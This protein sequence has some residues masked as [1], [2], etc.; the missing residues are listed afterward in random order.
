MNRLT[1]IETTYNGYKFRSRLEARWS[2]FFDR[3]NVA[4]DYES[5]GF[6]LSDVPQRSVPLVGVAARYL[7]DF[8]LPGQRTWVEVKPTQPTPI[9]HERLARLARAANTNAVIVIGQPWIVAEYPFGYDGR[10]SGISI[11]PSGHARRF[12]LL[13][14]CPF[15]GVVDWC[16]DGDAQWLP[17]S[18]P[19]LPRSVGDFARVQRA[20]LA[21]RSARFEFGQTPKAGG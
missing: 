21:A 3:L 5:E 10:D 16:L 19:N 14:A 7:P 2:V 18:C 11:S 20:Y 15:C 4:Y 6:D 17:C 1:P 12:N 8:W 13:T 9:E